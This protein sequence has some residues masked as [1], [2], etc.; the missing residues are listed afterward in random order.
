MIIIIVV[1]IMIIVITIISIIIS[2]SSAKTSAL[3]NSL[4]LD[5]WIATNTMEGGGLT[6]PPRG[7]SESG[8]L[9][10]GAAIP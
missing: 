9:M 3:L 4:W 1:I 5:W 8:F 7:E 6:F 2:S 10:E